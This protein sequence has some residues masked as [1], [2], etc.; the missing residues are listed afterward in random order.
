MRINN[1]ISQSQ[2]NYKQSFKAVK[3]SPSFIEYLS[4]DIYKGDAKGMDM[5]YKTAKNLEIA[6]M[7]NPDCDI[8]LFHGVN[9]ANDSC[10]TASIVSKDGFEIAK[11]TTHQQSFNQLSEQDSVIPMLQ[12]ANQ[13]ANNARMF[14]AKRGLA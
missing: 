1:S 5:F 10:P 3:M 11:V 6:Q 13:I 12:C 2:N 4:K 8:E 7:N 14:I 9:F